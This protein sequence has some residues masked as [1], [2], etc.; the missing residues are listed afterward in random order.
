MRWINCIL[1]ILLPW[2][3]GFCQGKP[4][5]IDAAPQIG[6]TRAF[7]M[8]GVYIATSQGIEALSG[9]PGGLARID[10]IEISLQGSAQLFRKSDAEEEYYQKFLSFCKHSSRYQRAYQ[11]KSIGIALPVSVPNT[12][13]KLVGAMGHHSFYSWDSKRI[14]EKERV[15]RERYK[16]VNEIQSLMD[17]FSL[18][19]GAAIS[20]TC[21][22]G[23]SINFPTHRRYNIDMSFERMSPDHIYKYQHKEE[24][25]VAADNFVQLGS[26]LQLTSKLAVGISCL[27][28]HGFVIKEGREEEN[29]N[30]RV[31][32]R[33]IMSENRWEIPTTINFGIS[34]RLKPGLLLAADILPE[35]DVW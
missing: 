25:D 12:S 9:N 4:Q 31:S 10:G 14:T 32:K 1:I 17:L 3:T 18:G 20:N 15:N 8:G 2:G 11:L 7:S 28:K 34:Y 6:G 23:L 24:W 33:R 29:R 22:L 27:L 35:E 5:A 21:F 16:E 19:I 13:I 30:G 26:I